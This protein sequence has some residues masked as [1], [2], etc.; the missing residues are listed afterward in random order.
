VT[1]TEGEGWSFAAARIPARFTAVIHRLAPGVEHAAS[2]DGVSTLCGLPLNE[3]EAYRH[4][5]GKRGP[6]TDCAVCRSEAEAAPSE[7]SGQEELHDRVISAAPGPL[8]DAL[9]DGLSRGAR[10]RL[11]IG[12][13]TATIAQHYL[14]AERILES[15]PGLAAAL[16]VDGHVGL[17][18][19]EH[20]PYEYVV[21]LPHEG[22]PLVARANRQT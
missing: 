13:P 5:F 22:P 17:A 4:F 20:G 16:D 12:G 7:P 6:A 18:R 3:T 1:P 2:P 10:I 15:D 8:R 14:P 21:V 19:V 9:L 11:W